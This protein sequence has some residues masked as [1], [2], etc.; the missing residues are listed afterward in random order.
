MEF[1]IETSIL[2]GALDMLHNI[3]QTKGVRP[4][5]ANTLID[6]TGEML[7]ISSTDLEISMTVSKS[8]EILE[9]GRIT[10]PTQELFKLAGRLKGDKEILFAE[11]ENY[12]MNISCGKSRF[13]LAG[14]DPEEYPELPVVSETAGLKI[15][16]KLFCT[17]IDGCLFSV[18]SDINKKILNGVLI[19]KGEGNVLRMVATDGHRMALMEAKFENDL[20]IPEKGV[21]LPAKGLKE[22]RR[23]LGGREGDFELV[24]GSSAA[25]AVHG[26]FE[27]VLRYLEGS[28]P[29]YR[30]VVPEST[31]LKVG[32]KKNA[33][34]DA[35]G[36]VSVFASDKYMGVKFSIEEKRMQLSF[37]N[38]GIGEA[39]EEIE[40]EYN[41]EEFNISFN[42]RYLNDIL[43]CIENED[44]EL[45][46]NEPQSPC[47]ITE[48]GEA[49]KRLYVVMPMML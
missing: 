18:S 5:L 44:T 29:E 20:E 26:D 1:K 46:F 12:W 45:S 6:G 40:A 33:L 23:I 22:L 15:S 35:L 34:T 7:K 41:G 42:A 25:R 21:V 48:E 13:K 32:F 24:L 16:N 27:M 4:I 31:R 39:N 47:V 9:T 19:E 17:L 37:N 10:L 3:S 49:L 11:D 36:R 43:G 8:S 14:L 30:R 2:L 28:F 38:P